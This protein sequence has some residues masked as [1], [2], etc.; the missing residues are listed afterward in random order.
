MTLFSMKMRASRT[1]GDTTSHVS[2]AEKILSEA[3]LAENA[4]ALIGRALHHAKGDADYIQLKIEKAAPEAIAYID[5]LPVRTVEAA[6]A[7]EGRAAILSLLHEL[8]LS[9]GE[10]IMEKFHETYAMRG[11]M[12]LD[13]DTLERLEPDHARGIRAT[14]M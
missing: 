4:G 6:D 11:A 13:A 3:E 2:G 1:E 8:G 10:A 5:A 9:N 14:Y 7:A 12:L